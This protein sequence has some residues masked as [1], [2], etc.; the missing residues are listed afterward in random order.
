VTVDDLQRSDTETTDS[1][2]VRDGL[3][4]DRT[5]LAN[6]RT[7]LA[8]IRTAI[9]VFAT[10]VGLPYLFRTSNTIVAGWILGGSSVLLLAWG[11]YRFRTEAR[12]LRPRR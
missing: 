1:P 10:G 3:A 8:Y 12:R 6:E 9:A 2:A 5:A 7:L 11:I 4:A